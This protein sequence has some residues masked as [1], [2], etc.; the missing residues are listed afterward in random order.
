MERRRP[1]GAGGLVRLVPGVAAATHRRAVSCGG[2]VA[3][4]WRFPER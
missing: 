4:M 2:H 1:A 3:R